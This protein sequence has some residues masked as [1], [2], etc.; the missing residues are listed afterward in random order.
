MQPRLWYH[1]AVMNRVELALARFRQKP[2][3]YNCAQT[4]CAAFGREDLV[5]PMAGCGGGRAPQGTCGALYGAMQV[6]PEKA[7]A[8]LAAFSASCG[9]STCREIKGE[10]RV[11]CQ[12]CV[13]R[14]A[15]ILVETG[16]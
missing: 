10:N 15:T 5:E 9:A 2:Y 12:E 11:P 8:I 3:M 14:A 6:A 7:A 13:R 16:L 4:V 1:P